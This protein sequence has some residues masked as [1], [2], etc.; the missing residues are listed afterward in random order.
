[1]Y[2][3][4]SYVNVFIAI[5]LNIHAFNHLFTS[6]HVLSLNITKGF[7]NFSVVIQ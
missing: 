6:P 7:C 4:A 3:I 1:M 2:L 5:P